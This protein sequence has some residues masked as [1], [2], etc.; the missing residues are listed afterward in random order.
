MQR[1]NTMAAHILDV[2]NLSYKAVSLF[3]NVQGN[4]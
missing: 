4:N 2:L 3:K 1:V